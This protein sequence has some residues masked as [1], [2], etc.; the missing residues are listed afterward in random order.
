MKKQVTIKDVA[1]NAGVSIATVSHVLHKTRYVSDETT[2]KVKD[3]ISEL[4]YYPNLLVGSLRK[5][6]TFSIGLIIPNISNETF[7]KLSESI[8]RILFED[9]YNVIIC[10]TAN[11]ENIEKEALYTLLTKKV[12][13]IIAIPTSKNIKIF[14]E[15]QELETPLV[16]IDRK[17]PGLEVDSVLF[18]NFDSAYVATKHLLELGHRNIGYIDRPFDHSHNIDQR[19]GFQKALKEYG[20]KHNENNKIR[21]KNFD[22][23][24]GINS[25]KALLKKNKSIT[26][27]YAFYDIIALGAIRG[28]F[29][30]GLKVPND[31]SV[32]G[33]DGMPFTRVS[34]PKLTTSKIPISKVSKSAC[35]LILERI[36]NQKSTKV[37]QVIIKTHL[38]VGESTS[39]A[40][41]K[42]I[43]S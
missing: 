24:S 18:D 3:V 40:K 39:I 16:F 42:G 14:K 38:I 27:I 23:F 5:R 19:A 15:I 17:I 6:R 2:K 34:I 37:E 11:D 32:I 21:S 28:I 29:D 20:I 36:N 26:A 33:Y 22:Y 35:R 13:G 30:L 31:I 7:G 12:D 25:V 43:K 1:K 9:D 10:N 4:R 41:S 8:Q